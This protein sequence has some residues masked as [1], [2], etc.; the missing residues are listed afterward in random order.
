MPRSQ[1][2]ILKEIEETSLTLSSLRIS[3]EPEDSLQFYEG[4]LQAL[5]WVLTN[6]NIDEEGES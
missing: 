3:G 4:W 5:A 1:N 2:E 6:N